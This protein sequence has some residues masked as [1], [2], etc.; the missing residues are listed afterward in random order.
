M[1][2]TINSP[3]NPNKRTRKE[4]LSYNNGI[5]R[6]GPNAPGKRLVRSVDGI[7]QTLASPS[8]ITRLQ[9][10][11]L[12]SWTAQSRVAVLAWR[13]VVSLISLAQ[14]LIGTPWW[15][16]ATTTMAAFVSEMAASMLILMQSADGG[17]QRLTGR[18]RLW[19][20]G[21]LWLWRIHG[22]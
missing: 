8:K 18:G 9:F 20:A 13:G 17:D 7:K 12:A 21:V 5:K 6:L 14:I 19:A 15:S 16:R 11:N 1:R 22:I 2:K 4:E 10:S 3:T